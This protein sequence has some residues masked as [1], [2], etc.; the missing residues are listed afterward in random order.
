MK[1]FKFRFQTILDIRVRD[2]EKAELLVAEAQHKVLEAKQKLENL[3][4]EHKKNQTFLKK[5]LGAGNMIDIQTISNTQNYLVA[6]DKRMEN[7]HI[8]IKEKE[9]MLAEIRQ[10][11]LL[12][13]QKKL[14][15]DKLKEND[16]KKYKKDYEMDEMK[17][18]DEMASSRYKK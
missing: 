3:R 16:F 15:M 7:Q 1:K 14:M 18:I 9:N 10:E 6:L 13:R 5:T 8:V 11:M 17:Q 2:L 4:T 12:V